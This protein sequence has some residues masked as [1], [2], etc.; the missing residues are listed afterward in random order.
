ML[1]ALLL[2]SSWLSGSPIV[3]VQYRRLRHPSMQSA[4][5]KPYPA[6]Q[7]DADSARH[8]FSSRPL[9]VTARAVELLTRSAGFGASLLVDAVGGKLQERADAR[10]LELATLLTVLGPTLCVDRI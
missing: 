6:G 5:D 3:G 10:G 1:A 8:F 2:C 9:E 4:V 7:Y